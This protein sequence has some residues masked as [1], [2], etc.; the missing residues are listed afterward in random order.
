MD[1]F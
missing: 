1:I